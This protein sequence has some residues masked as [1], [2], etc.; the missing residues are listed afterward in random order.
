[1]NHPTDFIRLEGPAGTID[2]NC[3]EMGITW[4]PPATITHLA[5]EPLDIPMTLIGRSELADND[6]AVVAGQVHRGALYCP[7]TDI[8]PDG[9]SN[10]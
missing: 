1:M 2:I 9:A 4:P 8:D 7:I 10:A 5:G 6:L 3:N